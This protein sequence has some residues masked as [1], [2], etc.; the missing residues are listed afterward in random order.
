MGGKL[1]SLRRKAAAAPRLPGTPAPMAVWPERLDVGEAS[2]AELSVL[3]GVP[4][5]V[6]IKR[7]MG[8]FREAERLVRKSVERIGA[9]SEEDL[10]R[11]T[12]RENTPLQ[13]TGVTEM[14]RALKL[15]AEG[16][17][18]AFGDAIQTGQ[19][20]E[21]AL[22]ALA[23]SG[24]HTVV[25]LLLSTPVYAIET[26]LYL[27]W[28]KRGK[29]RLEVDSDVAV[30]LMLTDVPSAA[31][32]RIELPWQSFCL[33]LPER[34]VTSPGG[35][36][37]V[38]EAYFSVSD[39]GGVSLLLYS[40]DLA[41]RCFPEAYVSVTEMLTS[42]SQ[43]TKALG[44]LLVGLS[45]LLEQNPNTFTRAPTHKGKGKRA[46]KTT[47]RDLGEAPPE[48][49][50]ANPQGLWGDDLKANREYLE[51]KLAGRRYTKER[52]F[53]RGHWRH[54]RVG[55]GRTETKLT[56]VAPSWCVRHETQEGEPS[57]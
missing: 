17:H 53:R 21:A 42:E 14:R 3:H 16:M 2:I 28:I 52:W 6:Y 45:F 51:A 33:R 15:F 19:D 11:E 9:L 23:G 46:P 31:T 48:V 41:D 18:L 13:K 39:K 57:P 22:R 38:Y 56:R 12:E 55:K 37:W 40:T 10:A 49:W 50:F 43:T 35:K 32:A 20:F 8:M 26:F 5:E 44:L 29:P 1:R 4:K 36:G 25:R 24:M 34:L 47:R 54:Q 30:S 27:V 7:L